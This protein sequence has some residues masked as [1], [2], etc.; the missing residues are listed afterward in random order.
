MLQ[1]WKIQLL[2]CLA[3]G[4]MLN[5]LNAWRL[6]NSFDNQLTAKKHT[7]QI[8]N[9]IS[10]SKIEKQL[11]DRDTRQ[12]M[13]LAISTEGWNDKLSITEGEVRKL[14]LKDP[15]L[16]QIGISPGK[17]LIIANISVP[18]IEQQVILY[19]S[20]KWSKGWGGFIMFRTKVGWPM[21]SLSSGYSGIRAGINSAG[22]WENLRAWELPNNLPKLFP[23]TPQLILPYEVLWLG[24]L[25]NTIFFG[26]PLFLLLQAL[27]PLK[28]LYR[29][30]K[31]VCPMC[32][33]NLRGDLENGC[34]ECGW[35]RND[36]D[37]EI[38]SAHQPA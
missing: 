5:V 29:R 2:F 15:W 18:G 20:N 27:R 10:Y 34:S 14:T 3:I 25:T 21:R 19:G 33:Y 37:K 4:V 11:S 26:G 8:I 23:A 13:Y 6:I 17:R 35:G 9:K 36:K 28:S 32:A 24:F 38:V 1:S 31:G 22:K 30:R 16:S 12:K 7:S